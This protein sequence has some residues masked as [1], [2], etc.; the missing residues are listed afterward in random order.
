MWP[1]M[2]WIININYI[3]TMFVLNSLCQ[4]IS[5]YHLHSKMMTA[6]YSDSANLRFTIFFV[7]RL[8]LLFCIV[9]W[10]MYPIYGLKCAPDIYP[11]QLATLCFLDFFNA[12]TDIY[13]SYKVPQQVHV[14]K[15]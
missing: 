9:M 1:N 14:I 15:E 11:N 4:V 3:F 10:G 6:I 7:I 12:C 5:N 2:I 13:L 8:F